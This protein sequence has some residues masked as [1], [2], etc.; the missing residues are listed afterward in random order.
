MLCVFVPP[1]SAMVS[2]IH[3]SLSQSLTNKLHYSMFPHF[4]LCW[5]I[6]ILIHSKNFHVDHSK[7]MY[8]VTMIHVCILMQNGFPYVCVL[9]NETFQE[10]FSINIQ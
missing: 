2:M 7:E 4:S 1:F 10:L 3:H 8:K 5:Q 9:N 6:V